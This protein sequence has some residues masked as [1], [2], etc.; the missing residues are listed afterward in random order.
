MPDHIIEMAFD[1]DYAFKDFA[2]LTKFISICKK[3]KIADDQP[4]YILLDEVQM[5]ERV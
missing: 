1:G 3:R 2:I 5:L 4:Y